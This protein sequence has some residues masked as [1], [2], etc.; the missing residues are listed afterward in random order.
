MKVKCGKEIIEVSVEELSHSIKSL[1]EE[2]SEITGYIDIKLIHA[3][4][5]LKDDDT[6]GRIPG[7][8][9]AKLTMMGSNPEAIEAMKDQSVSNVNNKRIIDDLNGVI[10]TKSNS[11]IESRQKEYNPYKFQSIQ[12]LPNLP[13]EEKAREILNLLANDEGILAVMKKHKWSVGALCELY[14][15]GYVGVSDVCVMGLNENHGQKILLRLR[16]DDLKGFRKILSIRK[17]LCHELAHNV[18]SEHDSN[19]YILMR[20]IEREIVELDWKN[21]NSRSIGGSSMTSDYYNPSTTTSSA[22]ET[23]S[24]GVHRLGGGTDPVI[25][26]FIPARYL[27]GTAAIMRISAEEQEVEDNCASGREHDVHKINTGIDTVSV[28]VGS[29]QELDS[30]PASTTTVLAEV[31]EHNDKKEEKEEDDVA[32]ENALCTDNVNVL[33]DVSFQAT[34]SIDPDTAAAIE[35]N[36]IPTTTT[37]AST[38]TATNSNTTTTATTTASATT[39]NTTTS[40]TT[41][42]IDFNIIT[43]NILL[44]I[45]ETIAFT[46]SSDSTAAPVQQLLA[47]R[48]CFVDIITYINETY[49]DNHDKQ[50]KLLVGLRII[51]QILTNIK[52]SD[53]FIS[54][55]I[56]KPKIII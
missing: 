20:Q 36:P 22:Q 46:L 37:T 15:E 43:T 11:K 9:N 1:K 8:L 40:N 35:N 19:F 7:G 56:L 17:V 30:T 45:D 14:P 31:V 21:S 41:T 12:T 47:L 13:N 29:K 3:G 26:Q 5:V 6:I 2:L 18:H 54:Y 27:A 23:G 33:T 4:K 16:T 42:I 50:E 44:N 34:D 24:P 49:P 38:T 39:S 32:M 28:D 10:N 48:D 51:L 53:V 25:Q 52:V 55:F